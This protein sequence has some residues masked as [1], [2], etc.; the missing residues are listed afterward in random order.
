MRTVKFRELNEVIEATD[1]LYHEAARIMG[2]S[3]VEMD[4]YY[5][6]YEYGDGLKQKE[7][8]RQVGISKSTINSAIKKMEK[9]GYILLK[10][11]KEDARNTEIHLTDAGKKRMEQTAGKLISAENAVYKNWTVEERMLAIELNRKFLNDMSKEI[12]KWKR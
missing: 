4:I 6:L 8:Y 7:L 11:S 9:E 5:K 1:A 2:M 12:G 10:T 3:D